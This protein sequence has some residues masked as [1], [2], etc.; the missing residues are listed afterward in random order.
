MGFH[1]I[2]PDK[3]RKMLGESQCPESLLPSSTIYFQ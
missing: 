3:E 1:G 2:S